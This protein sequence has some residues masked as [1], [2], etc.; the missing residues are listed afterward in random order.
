MPKDLLISNIS[1]V[2]GKGCALLFK[3][4]FCL[5]IFL[6]APRGEGDHVLFEKRIELQGSQR[7]EMSE[8]P[9]SEEPLH[10]L[11]IPME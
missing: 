4:V 9:R 11:L 2:Q 5:N 10:G 7:M 8:L 3:E 6:N 1:T